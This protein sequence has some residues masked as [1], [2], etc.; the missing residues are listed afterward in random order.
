MKLLIGQQPLKS[1]SFVQSKQAAAIMDGIA[2]LIPQEGVDYDVC[3]SFKG[4]NNPSVSMDIIAH[5][6]KGEWWKRYVA[7]IIKKYPPVVEYKGERLPES[8]SPSDF[9]DLGEEQK[10]TPEKEQHEENSK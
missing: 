5:T 3:I 9:P 4:A 8:P 1:M 7:Q 6:D 10:K 2:R